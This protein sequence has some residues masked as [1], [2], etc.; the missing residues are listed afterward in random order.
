M[1]LFC[2]CCI[3][4]FFL[5]VLCGI[6]SLSFIDI[7]IVFLSHRFALVSILLY[8]TFGNVHR[9]FSGLLFIVIRRCLSVC[10]QWSVVVLT[11]F[12]C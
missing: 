9:Q 11:V 6:F 4:I 1:M 10:I 5:L 2:C 7:S 12:V 3:P 8:V